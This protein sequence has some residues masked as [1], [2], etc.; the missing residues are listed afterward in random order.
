MARVGEP[1]AD[2]PSDLLGRRITGGQ[3]LGTAEWLV[4][5]DF[6][7]SPSISGVQLNYWNGSIWATS[8]LKR[9]DGSGWVTATLKRYSGTAWE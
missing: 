5:D 8:A 6:F 9:W 7:E 4:S 3:D 2:L 1:Q